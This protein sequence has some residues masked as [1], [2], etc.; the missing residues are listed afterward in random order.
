MHRQDVPSSGRGRSCA[1]TMTGHLDADTALDTSDARGSHARAVLGGGGDTQCARAASHCVCVDGP[2]PSHLFN[3]LD[4]GP[5]NT[6]FHEAERER[7]VHVNRDDERG[8][9]VQSDFNKS[10][11][12]Q[13]TLLEVRELGVVVP[14]CGPSCDPVLA[15]DETRS[16]GEDEGGRNSFGGGLPVPIRLATKMDAR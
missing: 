14:G 9:I 5:P 3:C 2:G 6:D 15:V 13:E 8:K 12:A 1:G 4:Q 10:Q 16:S 11:G 7:R